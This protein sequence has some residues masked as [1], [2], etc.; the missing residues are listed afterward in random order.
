MSSVESITPIEVVRRVFERLND[1][2]ADARCLPFGP[3][4]QGRHDSR[5]HRANPIQKDH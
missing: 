2:D 4:T 1:R 3:M 5:E